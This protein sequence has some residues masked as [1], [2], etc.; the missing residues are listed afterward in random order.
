MNEKPKISVIIPLYNTADYIEQTLLCIINQTLKEIEIIIINDGSTDNSLQIVNEIKDSRIRVETQK[1]Q[2]QSAARNRGL[3]IANGEYI[4]FMDSDDLLTNDALERC[5][6]K[7]EQ[8]KL[9]FVFFNAELFGDNNNIFRKNEYIRTL[10]QDKVFSGIEAMNLLIDKQE[11]RVS[12]C[13][14][15]IKREYL[16]SIKLKF[17]SSIIHEDELFVTKLYLQAKR[18]LFIQEPFFIRRVRSNSIMTT[19]ISFRNVE[20][21]FIVTDEL[22]EFAKG[23]DEETKQTINR[24]LTKMINAVFFKARKLPLKDKIKMT[25]IALIKQIKYT[26]LKSI[27]TLFIKK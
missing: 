27:I 15:L 17:Y 20:C 18:V 14:N 26:K 7:C 11:Y 25:K 16:N 1:N 5:Y 13:L 2:G 19:K 9:D 21:Y 10:P 4:Y 22:R 6:V 23:K 24:Y 8:E 12:V 3:E